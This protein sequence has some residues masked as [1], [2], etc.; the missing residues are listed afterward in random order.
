MKR[1]WLFLIIVAVGVTARVMA[2][3]PA[4]D[5]PEPPVRLKKKNKKPQPAAEQPGAEKPPV[6][7]VEPKEPEKPKKPDDD[8]D[9]LD[10]KDDLKLPE[11]EMVDEEELLQR[12][13]K[14][15]RVSE[16][17]LAG[18][19]LGEGTRQVQDDILKDI[20]SLIKRSQQSNQNQNQKQQ[21]QD[22]DKQNQDK[23]AGSGGGQGGAGSSSAKTRRQ[24]RQARRQQRK[25]GSSSSR[26]AGG[27]RQQKDQGKQSARKGS[28]GNGQ[29][30]GG[31]GSGAG[32]KENPKD[33]D[34]DLWGHLP[35]RERQLMNKEMEQKFMDKYDELTKAYYRIIAEKSRRK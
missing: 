25:S 13:A 11:G 26:T 5:D 21:N 15:A 32:G 33:R 23:Q 35:E 2:E 30:P 18:R 10:N 16:E 28:R 24:Q 34:F 8:D 7:P 22:K 4:A 3:P 14:N 9:H 12:V 27:Q 17:R 1:S 31:G 19:E 6:K 20:D 29:T